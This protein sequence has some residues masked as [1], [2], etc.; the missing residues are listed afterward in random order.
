M[1]KK[2]TVGTGQYFEWLE[3]FTTYKKTYWNQPHTC[4]RLPVKPVFL[5]GMQNLLE[6]QLSSVCL[7]V[8]FW[9]AVK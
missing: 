2:A 7:V 4:C 1:S 3:G 6:H 9:L 8:P 5:N